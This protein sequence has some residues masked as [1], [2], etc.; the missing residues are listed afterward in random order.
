MYAH[1]TSFLEDENVHES[2]VSQPDTHSCQHALITA[3]LAP[4]PVKD[5]LTRRLMILSNSLPRGC[6]ILLHEEPDSPINNQL[7]DLTRRARERLFAAHGFH[8]VFGVA[9]SF[10][11]ARARAGAGRS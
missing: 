11:F 2:F 3:K 9:W 4:V 7:Y 6:E 1:V 10:W 8:K 5:H